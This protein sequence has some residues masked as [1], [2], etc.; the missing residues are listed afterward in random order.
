[1]H[2]H[3]IIVFCRKCTTDECQGELH[4][5]AQHQSCLLDMGTFFVVY[6]V[7]RRLLYHY[8]VGRY[9]L[10]VSSCSCWVGV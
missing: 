5:D 10:W 3:I 9:E 8:V 7:L 4:Y 1:M 6:E 2:P